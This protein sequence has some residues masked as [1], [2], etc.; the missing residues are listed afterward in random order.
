MPSDGTGRSSAVRRAAQ[1]LSELA[2]SPES[3]TI[4][5]LARRIDAP[6]STLADIAATLVNTGMAT[7]RLDGGL[8]LG[9]HV[10]Q[11]AQG[12]AAGTPLLEL[13]SEAVRRLGPLEQTMVVATLI[14]LDTAYLA[15]EPGN[16]PLPL[17]LKVGL[18]LPAWSTGTGRALLT[19]Y[20]LD[21]VAA[22]HRTAAP[23]SPRGRPFRLEELLHAL[24]VARRLGYAS[25]TEIGE[26]QLAGTA[27]LVHGPNGPVAAIGCIS[28]LHDASQRQHRD[29]AL[30]RTLASQLA[31][32]LRSPS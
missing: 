16:L 9:P 29:V 1:V 10:A 13:F 7:R 30:V 5:D 12:L 15:V 32:A 23:E 19:S 6:K 8:R 25:N 3:L 31:G 17:T 28:P 14:D 21:E 2:T 20:T 4:A 22:M 24:D 26:M 11:L 27:A 18:R